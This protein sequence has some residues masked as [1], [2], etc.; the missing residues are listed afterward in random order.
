MENEENCQILIDKKTPLY[1][2]IVSTDE[3]IKM[4]YEDYFTFLKE[5]EKYASQI[6]EESSQDYEIA[7]ITK[8]K[9]THEHDKTYRTLLGNK[10]D[11][12]YI[13]NKVLRM[14][15]KFKINSKELEKYNT[16]FITNEFKDRQ[17]DIVYKLKEKNV[18]FL[19]EHQSKVDYSLPYRIKEYRNEIIRSAIVLKRVKTK[20]YEI[21]EVITILIYTGKEK[22]TVSRYIDKIQDERFKNINLLK[23][24][25]I[26][27]HQYDEKELLDSEHFI[28]KMFLIEKTKDRKEF[29]DILEEIILHTKDEETKKQ[30]SIFIRMILKGRIGEQKG[31]ELIQKM[32]WEDEEMLA[33]V[34]MLKEDSKRL[35]EEGI[36]EGVERII[37]TMIEEGATIEELKKLTKISK[38]EL[39]KI[40]NKI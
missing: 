33:V 37:R 8:E 1:Y 12:A 24:N 7:N 20:E 40:K 5:Q 11:V 17:A 26:D 18:F 9:I 28:D 4:S 39:E 2:Y 3:I 13:I 21:P 22:W 25:L 19:I 35:R 36:K 23:Y 14:K 29:T 32:K 16:N 31:N 38:K 6:L 10:D 27:I 34:E 30:L 15:E